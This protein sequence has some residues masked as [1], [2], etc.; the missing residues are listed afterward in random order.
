[1]PRVCRGQEGRT[2]VGLRDDLPGGAKGRGQLVEV[3]GFREVWG[4]HPQAPLLQ[5][6]GPLNPR[7][8]GAWLLRVPQARPEAFGV[9]VSPAPQ[10]DGRAPGLPSCLDYYYALHGRGLAAAAGHRHRHR[11][12]AG[13]RAAPAPSRLRAQA[14][15]RGPRAAGRL[16]RRSQWPWPAPPALCSCPGGRRS[17]QA[18]PG[19]LAQPR[20][21]ARAR[22]RQPGARAGSRCHSPSA[23]CA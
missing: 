13:P 10:T 22:A 15:A 7:V 5:V 16:R 4:V 9:C 21:R 14:P 17:C 18:G 3:L 19:A 2:G 11:R 6:S 1:M 20:A 12:P 8:C 23:P